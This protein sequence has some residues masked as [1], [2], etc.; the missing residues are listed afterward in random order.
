[1]NTMMWDHPIT[2]VHLDTLRSW[3]YHVIDPISKELA[4]KDVGMGAMEEAH[5]I[6]EQVNESRATR[7]PRQ[8]FMRQQIRH[9][10]PPISLTIFPIHDFL[11][12]DHAD[13]CSF[14]VINCLTP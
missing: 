12:D 8:H 14:E 7:F 11:I 1:M 5:L 6:A 3:G 13:H 9:S 4:C 10:E 2:R